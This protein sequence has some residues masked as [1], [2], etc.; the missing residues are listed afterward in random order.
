MISS[1]VMAL[2]GK[3]SEQD[4]QRA[5][6]WTQWFNLRNPYAIA[7][8]VLGVFSLIEMGVLIVFGIAG[9]ALGVVALRQ[10]R[11]PDPAY[12][13]GHGFAWAGIIT[14]ALSLVIAAILYS[15]PLVRSS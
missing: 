9:I 3:P 12:P 13:R 14:S 15:L 2:F 8:T 6:A 11:V 5:Q 1:D 10:L 4:E 7:S